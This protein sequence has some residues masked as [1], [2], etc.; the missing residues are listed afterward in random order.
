MK[1]APG[2]TA[3][4]RT[5]CAASSKASVRVSDTMPALVTSYWPIPA[6]GLKAWV[7]DTLTMLPRSEARRS[8]KASR[9]R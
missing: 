5:P 2:Q 4:T 3:L 1:V 8:G 9:A 7:E 6:R